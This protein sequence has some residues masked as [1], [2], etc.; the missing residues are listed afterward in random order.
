M[1][2]NAKLAAAFGFAIATAGIAQAM[3]TTVPQHD[4]SSMTTEAAFGC[5]NG[6]HPDHYGRCKR[7]NDTVVHQGPRFTPIV[8]AARRLVCPPRMRLDP[9]GHRCVLRF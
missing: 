9:S 7:N 2:R 5:P 3:P 6:T 4:E 1:F 8:P